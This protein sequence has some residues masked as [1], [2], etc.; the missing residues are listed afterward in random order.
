MARPESQ[1]RGGPCTLMPSPLPSQTSDERL[2]TTAWLYTH[3][4]TLV[5][6]AHVR[7]GDL[8]SR[9]ARRQHGARVRRVRD[10]RQLFGATHLA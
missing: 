4:P 3:V 1:G 7:S 9:G 10:I 2:P 5:W 6:K 8:L